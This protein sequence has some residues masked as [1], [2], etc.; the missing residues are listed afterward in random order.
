MFRRLQERYGLDAIICD[1][2]DGL[3]AYNTRV[4][5]S[6]GIYAYM[7]SQAVNIETLV[8]AMPFEYGNEEYYDALA[9]ILWKRFNAR[10]VLL[11]LSN[12]LIDGLHAT[13]NGLL[14]SLHVERD[15]VNEMINRINGKRI[16]VRDIFSMKTEE[17][18]V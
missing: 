12:V 18:I 15:E 17:L 5:G 4:L 2:P 7:I 13:D 6:A 14:K 9:K 1:I 11:H 8:C 10:R 3:M 16:I